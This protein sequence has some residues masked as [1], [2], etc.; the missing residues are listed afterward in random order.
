MVTFIGSKV[1]IRLQKVSKHLN[2]FFELFF[3]LNS[4][5]FNDFYKQELSAQ[6][7]FILD[8][9]HFNISFDEFGFIDLLAN[10]TVFKCQ[11]SI[12]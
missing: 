9:L 1:Y 10:P 5:I 4:K 7:D 6:F 3:F 11:Q 8:F 12:H 2:D